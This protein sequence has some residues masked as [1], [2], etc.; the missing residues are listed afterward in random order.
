L[1]LGCKIL[2]ADYLMEQHIKM[3][4]IGS[5]LREKIIPAGVPVVIM[6]SYGVLAFQGDL[7]L[8][9]HTLICVTAF[10]IILL[11]TIL[12]TGEKGAINN[13][14][15]EAITKSPEAL[16][17]SP[18][19]ISWSPGLIL[20]VAAV[21]RV[22]FIFHPPALSDDLYRYL[23][24]GLQ[25]LGGQNPYADAP[26][27]IL[28]HGNAS[29][30]LL[31]AMNH[32][33][34][35]T[36]YPPGA[37]VVFAAGAFMGGGFEGLK[38]LLAA[39]DLA[40]CALI[41]KLLSNIGLPAWRAI[42]YAWHP[43]A[44]L[45]IGSSGHIDAAGIFF[46]FLTLALLTIPENSRFSRLDLFPAPGFNV[47]RSLLTLSAGFT[48]A[49]AALVKLFPLLLLPGILMLVRKGQRAL[50]L[51]GMTTGMAVLCVPFLPQLKN[52]FR[53][54]DLYI[55]NWEFSGF[56]FRTLREMMSSGNTARVIL[57][58][59]FFILVAALYG[60]LIFRNYSAPGCKIP[61]CSHD[62]PGKSCSNF[63]GRGSFL[64]IIKTLYII[65]MA[66]L[67]VTPTL[68]PWYA[69]YLVCLFPF[70]PGVAGIVLSGT[71]FL[72]YRVLAPYKLSGQWIE[73]D[74]TAGLIW[75]I[76]ALALLLFVLIGKMAGLGSTGFAAIRQ[77]DREECCEHTVSHP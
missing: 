41:I 30:Y 54:L 50:F 39:M 48:F 56:A 69:L 35:T 67:V 29:G 24:D 44:V 72:S 13:G 37:Q 47:K 38:I 52:M 43:L 46:I 70:I 3:I 7:G 53:T 1:V 42:L 20:L 63:P 27:N 60:R 5:K 36:I 58:S 32:P 12:Y 68:Y 45:E 8:A 31:K 10:I 19:A 59:F 16:T 28:A 57:A 2:V 49:L 61:E 11:V 18:E 55:L 64:N 40:T 73:N 62:M 65:T 75:L 77:K 6:F 22:L 71:I 33:E 25:T 15:K 17:W 14:E 34:L 51:M 21:V 76:P 4:K 74:V 9:F 26:I 23:W 66:F